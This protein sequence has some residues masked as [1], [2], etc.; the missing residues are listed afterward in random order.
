MREASH[1]ARITIVSGT[2]RNDEVAQ[3]SGGDW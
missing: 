2:V 1:I 3:E